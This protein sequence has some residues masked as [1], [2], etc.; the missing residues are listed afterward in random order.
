MKTD[1]RKSV[2]WLG[3]GILVAGLLPLVLYSLLLGHVD[4]WTALLNGQ[5]PAFR[6]S[7]IFEQWV[8]VITALVVKPAYMLISLVT[9]IWLWRRRAPDLT[10]LRWGLIVFWLGEA[11]CGADNV[12]DAILVGRG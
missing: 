7:S 8:V 12:H 11:A 1:Q 3:G 5:A 4:A 9:I 6:A 2:V 10:A